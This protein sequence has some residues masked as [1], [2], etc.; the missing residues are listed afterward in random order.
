V[1]YTYFAFIYM[2]DPMNVAMPQMMNSFKLTDSGRIRGRPFSAAAAV[3]VVT[4]I[5]AG[6]AGLLNMLYHQGASQLERWPFFNWADWAFTDLSSSLRN[7]EAP[8]NWLRLGV[9]VGAVVATALVLLHT[10]VVWWPVS[11]IGFL[12]ASTYTSDWILWN[13]ALVAWLLTSRIRR[14]G[15]LRLYRSFRPAFL[16]L[17]LGDYLTSALFAI[18]NTML[19]YRRMLGG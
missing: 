8:N 3:A 7:P 13:N 5:V 12:I 6:T 17:I 10:Y 19:D 1:I 11:P 16:G 4:V 18:L 14:Y 9:G 2:Q 15:G